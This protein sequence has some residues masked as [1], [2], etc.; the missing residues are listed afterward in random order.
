[1]FTVQITDLAQ[2]DIQEA[3]DWWAKNRSPS[4]AIHWYEQIVISIGTLAEMP[5]RCPLVAE[6]D[7]ARHGIRQLLFGLGT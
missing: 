2:S 4:Q 6:A 3:F 5:E 1:M 7:L